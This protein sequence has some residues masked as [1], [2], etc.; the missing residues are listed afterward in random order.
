MRFNDQ[1]LLKMSDSASRAAVLS[2][3]AL[4]NAV[5]AS[6][7]IEENFLQG[8]AMPVFSSFT[9]GGLDRPTDAPFYP[10][11]APGLRIDALWSGQIT[12][13]SRFSKARVEVAD[14]NTL[15]LQDFDVE[16]SADNGGALPEGAALEAARRAVLAKRIAAM[17]NSA[18]AVS[19]A[20]IDAFLEKSQ[21]RSVGSLLENPNAATLSQLQLL[22]SDPIGGAGF[23]AASFPVALALMIR[24]PAEPDTS[25]IEMVSSARLIQQMMRDAGFEPRRPSEVGGQGAAA[26]LLCVPE[27]WFDD[28]DWPGA[29]KAARIKAA[30]KW[31]ARE[32]IGLAA[33]PA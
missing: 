25:L 28:A 32:G 1:I 13:E 6:Y 7:Q 17:D 3:A 12:V 14:F 9:L 33:M 18:E 30:G 21:A 23:S 4:K 19:E 2:D 15:T 10:Q 29:D 24:D 5:L 16:V 31:M 20:A 8:A 22:I 26:V 27:S 11:P